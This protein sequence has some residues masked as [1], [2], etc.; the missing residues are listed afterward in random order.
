MKIASRLVV[1]LP[2]LLAGL[3][4]SAEET[5][6]PDN[7]ATENSAASNTADSNA[8]SMP[9]IT[10][11]ATQADTEDKPLGFLSKEQTTGALGNRSILD[12][13]FSMTVVGD[14]EILERGA[15]SIGQI[16][17]ND[18]A[19][20]TPTPSMATDWW[21]TQ[22]RGL[23]VRNYY[24]D[25]IPIML[26]WGGDLPLEAVESVTALKG[27]TGFMYGFGEPGGALSYV[28]KRPTA[29]AET[30][31]NL[32]YRNPTLFSAHIDSSQNIGDELAV[33]A[34]VAVEQG[35]AYN[36]SN[37]DRYLVALAIDKKFG[38]SVTWFT[39]V[40]Y[41]EKT[42]EAEP[43]LFY[44]YAYDVAGSGG[45]LPKP[46]YDYDNFNIDNSSYKTDT[47]VAS[48]GVD[49]QL[50]EHWGLKYQLGFSRKM[51]YANKS[52]ATLLDEQGNY[53]GSMYDFGDQLDNLFNQLMLR[54]SIPMGSMSHEITAGA[55]MSRD[56]QK[57]T[58]DFN[59]YSAFT[60]NIY[61]PQTYL[62]PTAIDY[63]LQ[64]TRWDVSQQYVFASDT[65][66][67][68][69]QWQAIAGL[70]FTKY[71]TE[72]MDDDASTN[73]GYQ[74]KATTPTV[75]LIYKPQETTS[76]YGSYVQ[77]LEPGTVVSSS[78]VN[79]GEVLDATTSMQYEVGMKHEAGR[80]AYTVALFH[81]ERANQREEM[82]STG[83]YLTQD[84]LTVYDGI[85]LAGAYQFTDAL[86]L[87][88]SVVYLDASIE[89]VSAGSEDL[90]GN[91]PGNA[92]DWQAVAN[93]EYR[94]ASVTGLKL[95]GNV[96][97]YGE[98]YVDD[99]NTLKAPDY[100][101]ANAGLSYDLKLGKQD[102]TINGNINNL[103]NKKYWAVGGWGSA[104][105]GEAI[106]ASLGLSIKL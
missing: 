44:L 66:H 31:I 106:N 60:G 6:S 7:T 40:M 80:A 53:D 89:D 67:F 25:D 20:S 10:V 45:K 81:V 4:A 70:R 101:L 82:R 26:Y 50:G 2:L 59:F 41:E 51:H 75:A 85:E 86:N 14:K 83:R 93:A 58:D 46:S 33:R 105:M 97:Y 84:G 28:L 64:A 90:L 11:T 21:G 69:E 8:Q 3:T 43:F 94:V 27:L 73:S 38:S 79:E 48:T 65:L 77:G 68:N 19:V 96:R 32:G 76:I 15:K 5:P 62:A 63:S 9:T 95:H 61:Q 1:S 57:A 42:L 52:F 12:T 102:L 23:P 88:F 91:T 49:W 37:L 104:S 99:S 92:S 22:I 74:T 47:L 39:N 29:A 54:G 17:V 30:S 98:T 56:R 16:F 34:N 72:D 13:P 71:D 35:D 87:G 103:F 55:G 18:A 36:A 24:V 78:F 100:V